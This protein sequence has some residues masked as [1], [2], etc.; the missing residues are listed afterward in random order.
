MS[1]DGRRPVTESLLVKKLLDVEVIP[2]LDD[3]VGD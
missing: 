1:R 2:A 3:P